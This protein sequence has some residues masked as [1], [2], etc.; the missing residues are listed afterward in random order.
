[1]H[2]SAIITL[3]VLKPDEQCATIFNIYDPMTS[4]VSVILTAELSVSGF[5]DVRKTDGIPLA[6]TWPGMFYQQAVSVT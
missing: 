6:M 3:E 1:M 5:T 4:V 2:I